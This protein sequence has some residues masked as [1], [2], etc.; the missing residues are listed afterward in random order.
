MLDADHRSLWRPYTSTDERRDRDPLVIVGGRGA[1]LFD[2]E[3]RSYIDGNGSWWCN[4][5]GHNH[6]RIVESLVGQA[7][8][9]LHCSMSDAT[10]EAAALLGE[11]LLRIAPKGLERV[12]YSDNGSTAVETALKIAIQFWAQN[13]QPGRRRFV[14][15]SGAYHGDTLG[16]VAVSD[17]PAFHRLLGN[18]SSENLFV[19]MPGPDDDGLRAEAFLEGVLRERGSE[20]AA[21]IV[22]PMVQGASG[23]RFWSAPLLRRMRELTIQYDVLLIA[24]EVFVGYGRTGP[25]WACDHAGIAPDLLC[26]AKGFSAGAM[27]F[28]A[29]LATGRIYDGFAGDRAR[30]LKHGHTFYGN[31]L[32]AALAREVLAIY[33]EESVLAL[34]QERSAQLREGFCALPQLQGARTLGMV[35]AAEVGPADYLGDRGWRVYEAARRRGALVRPLGNTVYLVPPLNIAEEDL[36]ALLA[37]LA[38]SLEDAF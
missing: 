26:L 36:A 12:F 9:L 6:P 16:C 21:L 32:G 28:A 15:L 14:S 30:A 19:P 4:N 8:A 20:I 1:R 3:G 7:K 5:L 31:P 29:T 25:M 2:S 34:A 37:I 18:P 10:H 33:R 27:P 11:E 38:E 23:M 35:A 13:G 17:V 24:D 22:E